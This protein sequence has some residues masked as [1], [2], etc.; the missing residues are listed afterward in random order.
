MLYRIDRMIENHT[1]ACPTHDLSHLLAHLRF[2][3]MDGTLLA[4]TLAVAEL[5]PRKPRMGILKQ[6]HARDTQF[7]VPLSLA[8]VETYHLLHRPFLLLNPRHRYRTVLYQAFTFILALIRYTM[9]NR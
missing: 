5:A 6:L 3:A 4:G 7:L 2:V 8:A 1:R 9:S